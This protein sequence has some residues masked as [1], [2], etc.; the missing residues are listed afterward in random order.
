M[1]YMSKN[2]EVERRRRGRLNSHILAVGAVVPNITKI[3]MSKEST[4]LTSRSSRTRSLNS[5]DIEFFYHVQLE[6]GHT[7]ADYNIQ[8]VSTPCGGQ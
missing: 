6:D 4:L 5:L 1:E 3:H 7:L 2:L 8:K